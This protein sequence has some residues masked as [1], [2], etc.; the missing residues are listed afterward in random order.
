MPAVSKKAKI[1]KQAS[2]AKKIAEK[3]GSVQCNGS[4]MMVGNKFICKEPDKEEKRRRSWDHYYVLGVSRDFSP[5]ELK[6]AYRRKSLE[7][8]PDK[9]NGSNDAFELV[10][11]AY[12]VLKDET[13]RLQ[14]DE[15]LDLKKPWTTESH[16]P[17]PPAEDWLE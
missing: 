8:H 12:N 14:Y 5:D 9:H 1:Q 15:G 4:M 11:A 3:Q 17:K 7:A 16:E 10:G 2:P 13:Q 6:R